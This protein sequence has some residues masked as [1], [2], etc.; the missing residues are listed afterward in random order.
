MV[1]LTQTIGN[2]FGSGLSACGVLMN[3]GLVN[4]SAISEKNRIQPGKQPRSSI[5]PTIVLD[6]N[7]KPYIALGSPGAG[8]IIP[9]VAQI[10]LNLL[11]YKMTI[12]EANDAPRMFS[13][14]FDEKLYIEGRIPQ[15]VRTAMERRGHQIQVY[16]NFDLFFGGAQLVLYDAQSGLFYGSADKRRGG[17]AG[18]STGRSED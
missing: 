16:D 13:Q 3:N 15:E 17:S 11:D 6:Q 7:G 5:A 8:R 12:K 14:K 9:T 10:I 18:T 1:S 2:F 4:F